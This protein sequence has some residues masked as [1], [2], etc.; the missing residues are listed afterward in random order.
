MWN[1][2]TKNGLVH[3]TTGPKNKFHFLKT[4][5]DLDRVNSRTNREY[6][7]Y[8]DTVYSE[9]VDSSIEKLPVGVYKYEECGMS[10]RF[11]ER[12]LHSIETILTLD[13]N[14][15]ILE[16]FNKFKESKNIY[17]D[18]KLKCKKAVLLYGPP[19]TGKTSVIHKIITSIE[20]KKDT[21]VIFA[22]DTL[23]TD[24]I[25]ELNKD[26]TFK[27]LIFEEFT[28]LLS[29]S[30]EAPKQVLDFLDGEA[31]LQNTFII[32]STNYPERLP[33][34]IINR[35]GRFDNFYKIDY[36]STEDIKTYLEHFKV[37]PCTELLVRNDITISALKELVLRVKRDNLTIP[38]ILKQFDDHLKLVEK[39]FIVNKKSM[40]FFDNE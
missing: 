36:L 22:D 30:N 15:N 18:L 40:G 37:T 25:T 38:E 20:S 10:Y 13:G 5:E 26:D 17:T 31:G 9:L 32:A 35:Y 3:W 6:Q 28:N 19:G 2:Y 11:I 4:Q 34:N 14:V 1:K 27:V 39:D 33:Q 16:D 21:I 29:H 12:A 7:I 8:S 24:Y 23:S